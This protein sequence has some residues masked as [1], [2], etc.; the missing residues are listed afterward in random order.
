MSLLHGL[1]LTLIAV[2]SAC[3]LVG[4]LCSLPSTAHCAYH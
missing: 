3:H 2:A 4:T 1:T